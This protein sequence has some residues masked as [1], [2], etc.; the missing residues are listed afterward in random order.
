M[1]Y[2]TLSVMWI[3]SN[4]FRLWMIQAVMLGHTR[5]I[6]AADNSMP[7]SQSNHIFIQDV[8]AVLTRVSCP[9]IPAG[10][11]IHQYR[12]PFQCDAYL[13]HETFGEDLNS[14]AKTIVMIK[15]TLEKLDIPLQ[16]L[17]KTNSS[18]TDMVMLIKKNRDVLEIIASSLLLQNKNL[19][20]RN[21]W[22]QHDSTTLGGLVKHSTCSKTKN[23]REHRSIDDSYLGLAGKA[24][25][26]VTDGA[27]VHLHYQPAQ[28][29]MTYHSSS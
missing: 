10:W 4:L 15:S 2:S 25:I 24:G 20:V 7:Y 29:T 16:I 18:P 5:F 27:H 6:S 28:F 12:V 1:H 19:K 23:H 13:F 9:K 11:W 17:S 26:S 8:G 21:S 3:I 14:F 22:L